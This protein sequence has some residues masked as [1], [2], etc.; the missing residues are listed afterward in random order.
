MGGLISTFED[1]AAKR[2]EILGHLKAFFVWEELA[3]AGLQAECQDRNLSTENKLESACSTLDR[4]EELVE[5]LLM[6]CC[7]SA[8]EAKGVPVWRLGSITDAFS[9]SEQFGTLE[10]LSTLELVNE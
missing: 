1:T 2:Q 8:Y 7:A 6:S 10:M 4:E 5:R 9:L 3:L